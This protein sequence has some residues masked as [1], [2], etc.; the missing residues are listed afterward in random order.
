M[1]SSRTKITEI[2]TGLAMMGFPSVDRALAVRPDWFHNVGD[3]E[4]D[5][6]SDER[7]RGDFDADFATAWDHG[8]RFLQSSQGLRGRVPD[9]VEWQGPGKPPGYGPLLRACA[10]SSRAAPARSSTRWSLPSRQK[11]GA[12]RRWSRTAP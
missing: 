7:A 4:Y 3:A 11:A 1:A 5:L 9:R 10:F 8:V 12:P 2:V 6:L